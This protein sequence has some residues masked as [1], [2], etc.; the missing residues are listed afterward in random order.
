MTWT[1]ILGWLL[2]VIEYLIKIVAIG[3]IPENRRPSSST[4]WL[5]LILLLPLV[6]LPLFL[7]LGSP[8]I[9]RRR[10]DIQAEANE[11]LDDGIAHLPSVP[12]HVEVPVGVASLR[13]STGG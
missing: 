7:M 12:E 2:I 13:S 4:A 8:Y 5:L 6:G 11:R 10:H 9:N 3:V 1:V